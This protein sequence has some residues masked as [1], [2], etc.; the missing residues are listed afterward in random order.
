MFSCSCTLLHFFFI[1][2]LINKCYLCCLLYLIQYS[3][4]SGSLYSTQPSSSSTS[5]D[6]GIHRF[7]FWSRCSRQQCTNVESSVENVRGGQQQQ[8]PTPEDFFDES[9]S[10]KDSFF[11][12]IFRNVSIQKTTQVHVIVFLIQLEEGI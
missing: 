10:S 9:T 8:Q 3:P 12:P 7:R 5:A 11:L 2:F 1:F 4:M 6:S